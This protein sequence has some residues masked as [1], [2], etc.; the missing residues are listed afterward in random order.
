MI[1]DLISI[2]R[3]KCNGCGLCVDACYEG[4]IAMVNG[5]AKLVREDHCDGLGDCLPECP[6]GALTIIKKDAL[7]FSVEP[8]IPMI[9]KK[10]DCGCIE[11]VRNRPGSRGVMTRWP[12]QLRLVPLKAPFY[13][14]ADILVASDCTAYVSKSFHQDFVKDRVILIGCPKLDREDYS[15]RLARIIDD[16]DIRSINL[17]RIN[18]S[19]CS[20][21][22]RMVR[23][24]IRMCTKNIPLTITVLDTDGNVVEQ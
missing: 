8:D 20:E 6:T 4:A 24:A 11:E 15:Q 16:N 22:A 3:E 1:R 2:D 9:K 7:P 23:E 18:I 10:N 5:K 17:V 19:C 21:M 12:I 14:G 13:D